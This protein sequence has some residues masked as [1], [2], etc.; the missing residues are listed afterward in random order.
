MVSIAG[1]PSMEAG[2]P[3]L[4]SSE[5]SMKPVTV[6]RKELYRQVWE[7]PG[8]Q[9]ARKYGV[10]DVALAKVCR[11]H[12][13]PRPPR[14]WWAKK[15]HGKRVLQSPL[16]DPE[17]DTQI[18]MGRFAYPTLRA[19]KRV[20]TTPQIKPIPV[21]DR[22]V[23]LH[24]LVKA[25]KEYL[26]DCRD[27]DQWCSAARHSHL[28]VNASKSGR[29]RALLIMN[30]LVRAMEERGWTVTVTTNRHGSRYTCTVI[31]NVKVGFRLEET[32]RREHGVPITRMALVIGEPAHLGRLA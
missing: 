14:G 27:G 10:S 20:G 17:R 13:I 1:H 31:D 32:T 6:T 25:T 28:D 29:R 3:E 26:E 16:P 9:L 23:G 5:R 11:K 7:K 12:D 18:C 30:A 24:P 2:D 19:R 8:S 22:L 21:G 15:L 4:V